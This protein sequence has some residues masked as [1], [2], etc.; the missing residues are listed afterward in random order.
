MQWWKYKYATFWHSFVR[1]GMLL[2]EN[3]AP[4]FGANWEERL[5]L[6]GFL[7]DMLTHFL[8]QEKKSTLRIQLKPTKSTLFFFLLFLL[9]FWLQKE[10][11]SVH[12]AEDERLTLESRPRCCSLFFRW[13]IKAEWNSG[14]EV[15][16][17]PGTDRPSPLRSSV[18][19]WEF[20]GSV[21]T[22][23]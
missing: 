21:I 5:V 8:Q 6:W 15:L 12:A 14:P 23:E 19:L 16:M 10:P 9:L 4:I 13:S 17:R 3:R 7:W 1:R 22:M 2:H 20:S 18:R 11:V